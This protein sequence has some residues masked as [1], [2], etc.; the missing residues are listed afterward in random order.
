MSAPTENVLFVLPLTKVGP[1]Y[2]DIYPGLPTAPPT[3][4]PATSLSPVIGA[5]ELIVPSKW[6]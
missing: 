6:P 1:N 3:G 4:L 5:P 2:R